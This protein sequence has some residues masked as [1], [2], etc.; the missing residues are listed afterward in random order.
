MYGFSVGLA[1]I[2]DACVSYLTM[3]IFNYN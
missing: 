2:V 1:H 3:C